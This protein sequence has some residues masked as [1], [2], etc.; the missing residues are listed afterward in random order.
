MRFNTYYKIADMFYNMQIILLKAETW[1]FKKF[2]SSPGHAQKF[3]LQ[4]GLNHT[5]QEII[6]QTYLRTS[7]ISKYFHA[8]RWK[9]DMT[10]L[11]TIRLCVDFNQILCLIVFY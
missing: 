6:V 11:K 3:K 9:I 5:F 1:E 8:F 10:C 7:A 4:A 2:I